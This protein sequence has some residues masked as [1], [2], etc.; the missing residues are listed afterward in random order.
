MGSIIEYERKTGNKLDEYG[1]LII[2]NENLDVLLDIFKFNIGYEKKDYKII[3]SY[4]S[5]LKDIKKEGI[6][7]GFF[8]D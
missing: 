6:D 1:D 7:I 4:Y 2:K 5:L 8:G 3:D